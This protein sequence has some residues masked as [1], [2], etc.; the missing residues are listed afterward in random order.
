MIRPQDKT[1][2]FGRT[3]REFSA[4]TLPYAGKPIVYCEV[5]TWAA[6][7]CHWM[8]ENVLTHPDS[9]GYGIDPYPDD[10]KRGSNEPIKEQAAERMSKFKNW[11]W[12][13]AKS[14]DA[15][16]HWGP[17][18]GRDVGPIKIDLLY[19]D[20]SHLAHDVVMDWS[21]AWP[22]LKLGSLVIFDDY[23]LSRRKTDGVLR[24]DVA[25][26]AIEKSFAPYIE[27]VG[28]FKLQAAFRVVKEPLVGDLP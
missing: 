7:S 21:F 16:R 27:R 9:S 24:V 13:Y 14:Q 15:L 22:H 1:F 12:I 25:V 11:T 17:R 28:A 8:C 26:E 4:L 3:F 10:F 6:D 5:G 20:G 18:R 19:L 23:G 2:W